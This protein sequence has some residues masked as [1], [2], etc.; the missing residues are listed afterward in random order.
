[1]ELSSVLHIADRRFAFALD[2]NLF[3]IRIRT[4]KNDL[5][6]VILH[7]QDKYIP[8]KFVDTRKEVSMKIYAKDHI[9][10]YYEAII[11]IDCICLRYFFEFVDYEGNRAYFGNNRYYKEKIDKV[12]F[13][14]DLPQNVREEERYIVPDWAENKII[15]QIFP[16]RFA[17]S[18]DV[19]KEIWYQEPI[20]HMANL[21]GNLR[22]ITN[23]LDHIKELGADIIYMTPIFKS[24]SM[25]KYNISDYYLIDPSFGTKEDL[26]ELVAKAH[27]L[28]MKVI[29]DG[30][31]NHTG[32]DFF[33]FQDCIINKEESKYWDW[34]YIK[35]S[36]VRLE[37]GKNC[38]YK[39]FAYFFGMPKINENNPEARKYFIDVATYWIKEADIDGWRLDVADEVSHIFW[40]EFRKE[41]KKVKKDA[42]IIGEVWHYAEDFLDGD[43]WD[44]VMNYDF[45]FSVRE[46]VAHETLSVSEFYQELETIKGRC[47]KK[48]YPCLWNLLDSHDT[49]RFYNACNYDKKKEKLAI[50]LQLLLPGMPLI[51][52]GDEFGMKGGNDPDNRRGM[53]WHE[54]YQDTEFFDWYKKLI[55]IRKE[56]PNILLDD[57]SYQALDDIGI[58]I[59]EKEDYILIFNTKDKKQTLNQYKGLKELL[60]GKTFDGSID[61]YSCAVLKK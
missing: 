46:L 22:G 8:L 4:K 23:H 53:Y 40:R 58:L 29:L 47:H 49:E 35:N 55:H 32:T 48:L 1:M 37:W 43:E 24:T 12:E 61:E 26:V 9:F 34:Y 6:E 13:M 5:K 28:G 7:Y 3:C 54:E 57:I 27:K 19:S 17:S 52:Y 51:Y 20:S 14:F 2:K 18:I 60:F 16:A 25:H 15:Y 39:T 21:G 59:L 30:V 41:V 38:N 44:T 45:Y 56:N 42:L 10:D 31:F 36:P 33:A 50:A 11:D